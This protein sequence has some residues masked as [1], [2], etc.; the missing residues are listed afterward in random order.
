METAP[1]H[2]SRAGA[3][4]GSAMGRLPREG[5]ALPE[6]RLVLQITGRVTRFRKG[7]Q[8]KRYLIGFGAGSTVVVAQ[9]KFYDAASGELLLELVAAVA[10]H[11][12]PSAR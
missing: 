9:V 3:F 6:G 4:V 10:F 12:F 7:S 1:A 2:E 11:G 5:E 8:A